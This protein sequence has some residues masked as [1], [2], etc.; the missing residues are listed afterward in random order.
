MMIIATISKNSYGSDKIEEIITAGADVLRYNFS[1]GNPE[2]MRGKI[3][4]A[5]E[6]IDRLG[7]RGRVKILAD[8]PGGKIRLGM[9]E[10]AGLVDKPQDAWHLLE[11]K[12]GEEYL[13]KSGVTSPSQYEF[14]PVDHPNIGTLAT[15]GQAVVIADGELAFEIL[16][17]I[18]D[19]SFRARALNSYHI[20]VLKGINFGGAIDEID[21]IT[22][23]TLEH[24]GE[25][26]IIKPDMVAFSFVNSA[27]YV[28]RARSLLVE[29]G[30]DTNTTP[31]VAKL[32]SPKALENLDEI[33]Q[34]ADI[35]MVARGDLGLTTPIEELGLSQKKICAAA[36]KHGKQVIVATMILNSLLSNYVP[37]RAEVLDL[38][39]IVLD[40]ADGIMLAKE[41]GLS[42]TPGASVRMAR[43]II[44][45]VGKSMKA[46]A[47][48]YA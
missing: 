1:H 43:R 27:A 14:I 48:F 21:H 12:V 15:V 30:I 2:E 44:T 38:T 28:H 3:A 46:P 47:Q 36:K 5:H 35:L 22:D 33:A 29:H 42:L 39:N 34:A 41:T 10:A 19:D 40:G 32:E 25:L 11:V 17:I 26:H 9:I 23:K 6:V 18:G 31:I 13:F 45:A 16:E 20:P 24:I 7:V 37:S 4:V 8:L